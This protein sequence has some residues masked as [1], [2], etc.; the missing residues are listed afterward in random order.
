MPSINLVVIINV[1]HITS[2]FSLLTSV[3]RPAPASFYTSLVL[4]MAAKC[5]RSDF[6]PFGHLIVHFSFHFSYLLLFVVL[7]RASTTLW[8]FVQC[9][10]SVTFLL[11]DTWI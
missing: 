9:P 8:L 4:P 6:Y 11:N 5:L 10:W 2:A 1:V 3:R 7:D